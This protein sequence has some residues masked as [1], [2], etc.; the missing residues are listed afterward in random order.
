MEFSSIQNTV[1][2]FWDARMDIMP[3]QL[4]ETIV[5]YAL[6]SYSVALFVSPTLFVHLAYKIFLLIQLPTDVKLAHR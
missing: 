6:R 1:I 2:S 4:M 3:I 5:N